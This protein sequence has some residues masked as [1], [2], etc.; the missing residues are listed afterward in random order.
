MLTR[1]ITDDDV[2]RAISAQ[3]ISKLGLHIDYAY[4]ISLGYSKEYYLILV[5]DGIDLVWGQ[6]CTTHSSSEDLI[7]EFLNI[8]NLKVSSVH[9]DVAQE[10]IKSHSFKSFC[11]K[12]IVME[13]V[14]HYTYIQN[15]KC[16]LESELLRNTFTV[17]Y[18][19]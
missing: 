6:T 7:Q 4:V 14:P 2:D 5:V 15:A 19:L 12:K 8:T 18:E 3:D 9:F 1:L 10:F 13:P 11:Q 17:P 16:N